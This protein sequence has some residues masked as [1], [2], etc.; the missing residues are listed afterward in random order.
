MKPLLKNNIVS[1]VLFLVVI[2]M[3]FQYNNVS[4]K[5]EA[6]QLKSIEAIE[7]LHTEYDMLIDSIHSIYKNQDDKI[8]SIYIE[9]NLVEKRYRDE[10]A[11][12]D[13]LSVS[14]IREYLS[15]YGR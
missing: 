1:V 9:Y 15:K 11:S 5:Y 6:T 14:S 7:S 13:T 3:W 4:L 8:D 12:I 2:V 10:I